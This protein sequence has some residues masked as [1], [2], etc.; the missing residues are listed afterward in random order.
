PLRAPIWLQLRPKILLIHTLFRTALTPLSLHTDPSILRFQPVLRLLPLP[1]T[2]PIRLQF[3]QLPQRSLTAPI[4]LR[5]RPK[6]RPIQVALLQQPI[7]VVLPTSPLS[8]LNAAVPISF[9]RTVSLPTY[10]RI[11]TRTTPSVLEPK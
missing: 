1:L 2:T 7:P 10:A 11:G 3:P 6:L 4:R 5:L 8:T 9:P